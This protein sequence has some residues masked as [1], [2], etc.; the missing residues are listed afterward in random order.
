[1]AILNQD[2]YYKLH[3]YETNDNDFRD[4]RKIDIYSNYVSDKKGWAKFYSIKGKYPSVTWKM[5]N[6]IVNFKI[7]DLEYYFKLRKQEIRLK[8]GREWTRKV[9]LLI[10]TTQKRKTPE[11]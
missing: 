5:I 4:M 3:P 2:D 6:G 1:M 10:E 9:D 7:N 8:G 11:A